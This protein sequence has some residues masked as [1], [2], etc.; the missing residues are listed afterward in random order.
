MFSNTVKIVH[1]NSGHS[2]VSLNNAHEKEDF[3]NSHATYFYL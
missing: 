3:V 2:G 1:T